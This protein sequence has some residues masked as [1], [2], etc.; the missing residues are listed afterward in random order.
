ML[1]NTNDVEADLSELD[2]QPLNIYSV[3]YTMRGYLNTPIEVKKIVDSYKC[4]TAYGA[5]LLRM[6]TIIGKKQVYIK[7]VE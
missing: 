2:A 5:I 7:I 4:T 3:L 1:V 6:N